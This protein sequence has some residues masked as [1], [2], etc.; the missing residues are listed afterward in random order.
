MLIVAEIR[1][2]PRPARKP[3]KLR[4]TYFRE[5]RQFRG[6]T[7]EQAAE[8]LEIDFT[9]LSRI[10]RGLVP[11]SQGLLEAAALAY[12]CEPWDLLNV[13]PSKEGRVI[14]LTQLLKDAD[15]QTVAEIVGFARGRL[16]KP[17]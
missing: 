3:R 17:N 9:T 14:D 13:D 4:R 1:P 5:W 10:E 6:L 7:L 15:P 12:R 2:M 16:G 11:Y 8:R